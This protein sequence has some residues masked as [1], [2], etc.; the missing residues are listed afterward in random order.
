MDNK[1]QA[2]EN[3]PLVLSHDRLD[4]AH[5]FLHEMIRA[6]HHPQQFRYYTNAFLS[7]T[8]SFLNMLRID[9]EKVN[10]NPWRKERVDHL[11][12]DPLFKEFS[13]GRNLIVHRGSL[14]RGSSVDLG[15]FRNRQMKLAISVDVKTDVPSHD[16]LVRL[17]NDPSN[18]I[19]VPPDHPFL[20]EQLGV[21][22]TYR[23]K[24]LSADHDVLT[25]SDLAWQQV[26]QVLSDSHDHLNIITDIA[27]EKCLEWHAVQLHDTW[28]ETDA[29]PKLIEKWG[30][31]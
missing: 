12:A 31:N 29:D 23:E 4:E 27:A 5:W 2:H 22:R 21:K 24:T 18:S 17:Q 8:N 16:L 7:S 11:K 19:F 20:G 15:L 25:A 28:L 3:C 13:L 1:P 30:W 26:Q 10:E 9:L 14:I 6:Y